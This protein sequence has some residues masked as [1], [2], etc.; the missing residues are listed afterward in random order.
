MALLYSPPKKSIH[1]LEGSQVE[2]MVF[3]CGSKD[4][5]VVD[6]K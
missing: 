1:L 3:L 4:N 6:V 5:D 2:W